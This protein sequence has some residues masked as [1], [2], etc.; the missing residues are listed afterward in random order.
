MPSGSADRERSSGGT[1][2]PLLERDA[3]LA[4]I[5]RLLEQAAGGVG[6]LL[7]V[8]GLAGTGKTALLEA[9]A[10]RA[11]SR[12]TLV[13]EASGSEL[14]RELG[15]GV[16]RGLF[17]RL[18]HDVGPARRRAFLSGAASFAA[19][20]VWRDP[21][22]GPAEPESVLRGLYWL[23][24]NLS[25]QGPLMLV[26]DD[27]HWADA[28]SLRFLAYVVRRLGSLPVLMVV[29]TRPDESG[30]RD[31]LLT[32]PSAAV[33]MLVP[34]PLSE[35]AVAR[36]LSARYGSTPAPEFV[37]ACHVATGGNPFLMGELLAAL[38]ADRI[39][40]TVE[41]ARRVGGIGPKTVASAVLV[42]ISRLGPSAV[43]LTEAI[44][45]LGGG[46]LRQAAALAGIELADAAAAADALSRIGVLRT[47]RPLQFVHPLVHAAVYEGIPGG[48]RSLA[49]DAA[50]RLLAQDGA[51]SDR[52]ALHLLNAEPAGDP[53]VVET[54]RDAAVVALA[55]GAPEQAASTLR[56]AL[57]EPPASSARAGVLHELGAAELLAGQADAVE[58]LAQALDATEDPKDRGDIALLLGRAAVSTGRLAEARQLLGPVIQESEDAS[59]QVVARLEAYRWAAGVWDP[60]F[61]T[62]LEHEL[63]RLRALAARAG[64]DGRSLL[65]M[66]AFR[67]TFEGRTREEILD[68]V[69]Q[70]LDEGRLIEDE[71]A[72]AIEITWAARALTFIDELG[73]ADRLLDAMVTDS[74]RRGSVMGYA[75]ASAWRAAVALRRGRI[76]PAEADARAAV[77]LVVQHGLHVIA[78]HAYSFLGEAL[79]ER[80]E[81]EE[82]AVLLARADLGPMQGSRPEAR[83]LLTRARVHLAQGDA[84]TAI[85]E[86]RASEQMEPWFRNPNAMAWRSTLALALP[87]DSSAAALDL[88]ELELAEARRIGQPRAIGVATRA[89]ALLSAGD[90]RIALLREA[91]SALE[92]SPSGLEQA[93]A[94]TDLGAALRRASRRREARELLARALDLAAEC[95]ARVI[96]ARAHDELVAAGAR[97]RRDRLTGVDALTA[98][99]RRVA[100]MAA[101]GM[102]NR[103]IAQALFVTIKAVAMH[104][105]HAYEKLD[106]SGRAELAGAL[107]TATVTR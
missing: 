41:N 2:R 37:A 77:E 33:E 62:E 75:T 86:L 21:A 64:A 13:L 9:A 72:A 58:R 98:S 43:A 22:G 38:S 80:G 73:R 96:A 26:V 106:I 1:D 55:A 61:T 42:R 65:L 93:R 18:L 17:E 57:R 81:L 102:T 5:G 105:T 48:R 94:L 16:V 95:G 4:T 39:A 45:V 14:E 52:V 34:P 103:E 63:P 107:A 20:V 27:A 100:D 49:H 3:E 56:R 31:H 7:V 69:E 15:F 101:A 74:R 29:A 25:E 40:P 70:G 30:I 90:E 59:P 68:L 97:P 66:L 44:A 83:F 6:A 76:D 85:A 47:T 32:L 10:R 84:A 104:L 36:L 50:A 82:A 88:V 51:T 35:G 60:R 79:L 87:A 19:P 91:V 92:D 71:S 78:P 67:A 54:L 28:P 23:L 46:E 12:G 89:R 24:S 8:E 53:W 11:R 99:E